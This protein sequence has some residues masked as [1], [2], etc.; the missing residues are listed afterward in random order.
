VSERCALPVDETE[1]F[2][3]ELQKAGICSSK[4][5]EGKNSSPRSPELVLRATSISAQ[6]QSLGDAVEAI[7]EGD[8]LDAKEL[9]ELDQK[10]ERLST[11][12]LLQEG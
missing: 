1:G 9:N 5:V 3:D 12:S 7:K 11:I 10:V 8:E 6:G 2:L 4:I